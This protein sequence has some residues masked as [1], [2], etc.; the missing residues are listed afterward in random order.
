VDVLV[1]VPDEEAPSAGRLAAFGLGERTG[2]TL[3]NCTITI[4]GRSG[5]ATAISIQESPALTKARADDPASLGAVVRLEDC[6]LRSAGDGVAVASD[7]LLDLQVRNTAIA[8]DGSMLHA[9][10]S[11]RIDRSQ[12]RLSV[13][14]ERIVARTKGGLAYLE[15]PQE[16]AELPLTTI[17]T[18][19]SIFS[20]AGQAAL[21]RVEGRQEQMDQSRD[22]II[23][24]ADMAAYD[25]I[26]T[27]RRDQVLQT[28][29]SPRDY[30]RSDWR[31]AFEPRDDSP[32]IDSVQFLKAPEHWR[33][34][35]SLTEADFRLDARSP[36]YGRGPDLSRIPS[37][38]R[39]DL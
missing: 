36:A 32:V 8:T 7:R 26:T 34:A 9:L 4:A 6:F 19:S 21:L 14:L 27:Y 37:P 11:P 25:Q 29:V 35:C 20:T 28:G 22:R 5:N 3:T 33:S 13:K 12:P 10:G 18:F 38:P 39:A 2:L 17:E 30:S 1:Q 23:W 24:K 15:S 16:K 31:T